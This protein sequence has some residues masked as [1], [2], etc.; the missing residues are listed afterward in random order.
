MKRVD[1]DAL[2]IV[3]KSLGLSGSGSQITELEDGI[4]GQTLDIVPLARRGRTHADVQG[5]Y[6][7]T[8]RNAHT[9]ASTVTNAIDPYNVG[10]VLDVPPYPAVM[11]DLFDIWL[12]GASI[13]HVS[14][15]AS[16]FSLGTLSLTVGTR[17]QGFGRS[18]VG[19][20][21]L[22]AQPQRLA[23]WDAIATDAT[24]FGLL[25]LVGQPHAKFGMRLPRG[26]GGSTLTFVSVSTVTVAVDL[27]L[28]L[29]VFPVALGQDAAV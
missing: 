11:P 16:G 26:G 9:D 29:G 1:S 8:L 14:G 13:R 18:E 2:G 5:L 25:N 21:V 15:T 4:V 10:T 12:L 19:T 23:F 28:Q 20:L 3:T 6:Y 17:S 27:Q 22:V 7:P 24:A